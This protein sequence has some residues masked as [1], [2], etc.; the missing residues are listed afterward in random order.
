[1]ADAN[2]NRDW[3]I[4]QD[5]AL[6]L[7]HAARTLYVEDSFGLEV[8]PTVYALDSTTIDLC[9]ALVPWARFRTRKVP[10]K[11]RTLLDLR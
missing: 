6:S 9:L 10:V 4:S 2:E 1:M 5:F 3:R 7:I 11:I 8:T